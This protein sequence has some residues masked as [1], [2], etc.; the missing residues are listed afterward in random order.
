MGPF[1]LVGPLG[2]RG[3][4]GPVGVGRG[5]GEHRTRAARLLRRGTFRRGGQRSSAPPARLRALGG[6]GL[7]S[8]GVTCLT[9]L[10]RNHRTALDGNGP[11]A[12]RHRVTGS[13]PG[14]RRGK[15][16]RQGGLRCGVHLVAG[17]PTR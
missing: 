14:L 6:D 11:R 13:R 12:R 8:V 2:L 3:L 15:G 10:G 16:G 17:P 7:A 4:G 5:Q 9:T 1:T